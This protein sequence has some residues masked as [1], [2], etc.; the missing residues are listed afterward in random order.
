MRPIHVLLLAVLAIGVL[1]FALSD[2]N[3]SK[4]DTVAPAIGVEESPTKPTQ[5]AVD[6]ATT[7]STSA[8]TSTAGSGTEEDSGGPVQYD[9]KLTGSVKNSG[10][11]P[12]AG[13]EVLL[14]TLGASEIFFVNDP[15]PD[16]SK[17][18]RSRTDAE[19]RFSFPG[20]VPRERYTLI[21]THPQYARKEVPTVPVFDQ[22]VFEEP[23]IVLLPGARLSGYVK[24]EGG[25]FVDDAVL[26]LEGVQYQG[27]GVA[28][29]DRM[30]VK[31]NKEGWYEFINV[32][33]GQRTLTVAAPGYG[34]ITI[35]GL[36][37]DKEEMLQRDIVL[38]IG[39]QICGKVVGAGGVGIAGA[40]VI[41]VGVSATQQSARGQAVT[42]DNGDFCVEGLMPGSYNIVASAKGWRALPGGR[43]RVESNS[44]GVVL[45]MFKEAAVRGRVLDAETGT[46]V[47]GAK[48]R[49]RFWYGPDSPTQPVSEEWA[50]TQGAEFVIESAPPSDGFVV[51]AQAQGYAPTNS[52]NFTVQAG[53]DVDG[54]VVRLQRGGSITGRI[55]DA[56]G[57]PV[58]RARVT[59][60]ES[61]WTD[62]VFTQALGFT[63]PT[64]ATT[65]EA[66]TNDQGVFT[67][68]NLA[69]ESYMIDVQAAG[70]TR[71]MK[72]EL[73]VTE[74]QATQV[75]DVRLA[76]G[77]GV[78]GTVFDA[79]GKPLSAAAVSLRPADH[80]LPSS[81]STK[82]ASDGKFTFTA[83]APGRYTLS[84]VRPVAGGEAN[85]FS[86]LG[87]ER[88]SQIEVIISE[89]GVVTQDLNLT[90]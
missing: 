31:A 58:A 11:Q 22:G 33:R 26:W 14:T 50:V 61:D 29:P 88:N 67:L 78:Q 27:L 32:P 70:Y 4:P 89:G 34:Q 83:V 17:E 28:A 54:I 53:K 45:E 20:I 2:S 47:T 80:D 16:L 39:E 35:P 15:M 86:L 9:N 38:K 1:F 46:P 62:D 10:G 68:K 41:A 87:D 74:G 49:L 30:E 63:Y 79:A 82:S 66:R 51:E 90:E 69:A 18:P 44:S 24:D 6:L 59:S 60:H 85:P 73:R 8:R 76:R 57:K 13:A 77:G 36:N 7:E 40:T 81:Y 65:A 43:N 72:R 55:V 21:V 52:P 12:I 42:K 25:N 84:A 37:F 19:G 71:T 48:V 75:G 3:P 64:N 56:D 5:P 23:P